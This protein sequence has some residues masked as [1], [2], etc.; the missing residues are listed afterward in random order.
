[1][2]LEIPDFL[3]SAECRAVKVLAENGR[4]VSGLQTAAGL[5]AD[6]KNNHQLNAT[7]EESIAIDELV[8][9]AFLRD[10]EIQAFTQAREARAPILSRYQKGMFYRPHLDAPLLNSG[11][12]ELRTDLSM[13]VFVS[14]PGS[15]EGGSLILQTEY[16][17]IECKPK[18]GTAIV[19]STFLRHEVEEVSAGERLAIVT[20]FQSRV[21]D[22]M[23]RQA[24]Y[25][26]A[27][28][29]HNIGK[30]AHSADVAMRIQKTLFALTK[31]W[32]DM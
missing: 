11:E 4:F 8:K 30:G 16:G 29:L 24:L 23:Q 1:M 9:T 2:Y 17:D 31:L 22:P 13:T 5:T 25:D 14:D 32:S 10:F 7:T 19:Y 12:R 28:T 26:L 6:I 15:Y 20:W 27:M 21:R 18:A 3:T